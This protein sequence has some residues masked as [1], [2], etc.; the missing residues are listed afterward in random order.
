[1]QTGKNH[2]PG[3]RADGSGVGIREAGAFGGQTIQVWRGVNRIAVAGQILRAEI[4]GHDQ[5]DV[6]AL[7][8]VGVPTCERQHQ[9]NKDVIFHVRCF[10]WI[11]WLKGRDS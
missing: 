11:L 3:W 1:M 2:C 6:G 5:E 4:I 7:R 8:R 10:P 9:G